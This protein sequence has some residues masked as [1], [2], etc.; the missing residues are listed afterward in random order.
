VT[1]CQPGRK[2]ARR[3]KAKRPKKKKTGT[4]TTNLLITTP[5]KSH[6]V[7]AASLPGCDVE[8]AM[9]DAAVTEWAWV[10]LQDMTC[11]KMVISHPER[12]KEAPEVVV[13][14][15]VIS[16]P[17]VVAGAD[18][19]AKVVV[20]EPSPVATKPTEAPCLLP[21]PVV[22][23]KAVLIRGIIPMSKTPA[24]AMTIS[25]QGPMALGESP[26]EDQAKVVAKAGEDVEAEAVPIKLVETL[27]ITPEIGEM[28]FLKQMTGITRNTLDLL[29]IQRYLLHLREAPS[30]PRGRAKVNILNNKH[31]NN[32]NQWDPT[33]SEASLEA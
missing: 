19:A 17:A 6:E 32:L 8:A 25:A 5:G 2:L 7:E 12:V 16:L 18:P 4:L 13:D 31:L 22:A 30:Q 28:I 14:A 21:V 15:V 29:L 10:V 33:V 1:T 11:T 20:A 9:P 24:A 23:S 26:P 3:K 27:L